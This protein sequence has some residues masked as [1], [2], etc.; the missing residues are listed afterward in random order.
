MDAYSILLAGALALAV[1]A[2]SV[3]L[4]SRFGKPGAEGPR[5]LF[6][7]CGLLALPAL[8][9]AATVLTIGPRPESFG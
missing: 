4:W 1:L 6:R 7:L 8:M 5:R 3:G 2:F 9:T